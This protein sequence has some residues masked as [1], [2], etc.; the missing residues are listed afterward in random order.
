MVNT[1]RKFLQITGVG[2]ASSLAGC[3][4]SLGTDT[5]DAV[6]G[7]SESRH[8]PDSSEQT[9]DEETFDK[10]T[11]LVH[12][13]PIPDE[14][15]DHPYPV[16]GHSTATVT[17]TLYGGWK[18]PST[19][20]FVLGSLNEIIEEF[21]QTGEIVVEHR[22]V[23]YR[24]GEPLHG[25]DGPKLEQSGLAVWNHSPTSYWEFF[26]Y[27]FQNQEV[28]HGWATSQRIKS[29][30]DDAGV[31]DP[32]TIVDAVEDNTYDSRLDQTVEEADNF[33]I[34]RVPRVVINEVVTAPII[35]INETLSQMRKAI[36]E[37]L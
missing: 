28:V 37:N 12:K 26:E 24:D 32:E 34:I 20:D 29:I 9:A 35:D 17:A 6:N 7:E 1:R 14:P 8:Q 23:A 3:S 16:M 13:V 18:C 25:S 5:S 2:I 11:E 22:G 27:V 19:R 15:E 31:S 4:E 36:D 33:G 30:A 21:V 10:P